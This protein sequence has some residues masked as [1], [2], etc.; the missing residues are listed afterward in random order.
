MN[1]FFENLNWFAGLLAKIYLV[2]FITASVFVVLSK[3]IHYGMVLQLLFIAT[4]V[5]WRMQRRSALPFIPDEM[6]VCLPY[7]WA[8][9][10]MGSA[11]AWFKAWK[12]YLLTVFALS[13]LAM[14]A[15]RGCYAGGW[16]RNSL[17][18]ATACSIIFVAVFI[19]ALNRFFPG[20]SG[21]LCRATIM[22][23]IAVFAGIPISLVGLYS[24]VAVA[25]AV[26][27]EK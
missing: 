16:R 18:Q 20:F 13:M 14:P 4:L 22:N 10:N 15:C 17:F 27:V 19:G 26:D 6:L 12:P 8:L 21:D 7:F 1:K 5:A 2:V 24:V 23:F 3:G 11:L 9:A 25:P